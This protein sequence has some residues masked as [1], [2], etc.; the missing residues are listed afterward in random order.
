MEETWRREN[1]G[2]N[3]PERSRDVRSGLPQQLCVVVGLWVGQLP[4]RRSTSGPQTSRVNSCH[5]ASVWLSTQPTPS[6]TPNG[7][8]GDRPLLSSS[9]TTG[10]LHAVLPLSG[11]FTFYR[12]WTLSMY[13]KVS[14]SDQNGN[15]NVRK[16]IN[17]S[18][19]RRPLTVRFNSYSLTW[20]LK[21][22]AIYFHKIGTQSKTIIFLSDIAF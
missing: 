5:T 17:S 7:S 22:N 16:Y 1:D 20:S 15:R 9:R 12:L 21:H 19:R 13:A 6:P 14:L 8:G 18:W 11:F 3:D 2:E 4:V 10:I